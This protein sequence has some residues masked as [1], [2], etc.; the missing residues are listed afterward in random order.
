MRKDWLLFYIKILFFYILYYSLNLYMQ[1]SFILN[2]R[3]MTTLLI[4]IIIISIIFI[5]TKSNVYLFSLIIFGIFFLIVFIE[6]VEIFIL[7]KKNIG[8]S[9]FGILE[10]IGMIPLLIL[11][12]VF[13]CKDYSKGQNK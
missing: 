6:M 2:F 13:S 12:L 1:Y 9:G 5:C 10:I 7:A 8:E 4:S 11:S 3:I